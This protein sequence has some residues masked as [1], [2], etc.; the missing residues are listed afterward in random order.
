MWFLVNEP[1]GEP[2]LDPFFCLFDFPSSAFNISIA[3]PTKSQARSELIAD[4]TSKEPC[5]FLQ[6][7]RSESTSNPRMEQQRA[8][9]ALAPYLALTPT[10]ASPRAAADLITQ[11]TSSPATFVF[12]ELLQAPN[13]QALR[14]S[15]E[16]APHLRLLEI[17]AWGTYAD[18]TAHQAQ[19]PSLA[20]AQHEKLLLLS[21]LPLLTTTSTIT[22]TGAAPEDPCSYASLQAKLGLPTARDLERL[23][24]AA[25][26]AGLL[27]AHLDPQHQRVAV[28]SVAALRDLAPGALPPMISVL[29]DWESRCAS[30]L[31][32]I[33]AEIATIM[34]TA[35][36]RRQRE[37]Q[38]QA[39]F[40][41]A[42]AAE[43]ERVDA[44]G[45]ASKGAGKRGPT[46]APGADAA[47]DVDSHGQAG[48][49]GRGSKRSLK[50]VLQRL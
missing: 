10:A 8:L 13:I 7:Q 49:A 11:A 20:P 32:D 19:L 36:A 29:N 48:G 45:G 26:Y 33:E 25:V 34:A 24:Q 37:N 30:V 38:H 50:G 15:P 31:T 17:F 46:G 27:S 44:A 6:Q 5:L 22:A 18:Y 2:H 14:Q 28:S 23:V 3:L 16:Y 42:V 4:L 47:M 39:R 43:E 35:N 9:N 1:T 40:D 21:L 41:A 12:A